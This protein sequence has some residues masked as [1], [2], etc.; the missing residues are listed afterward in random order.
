VTYTVHH[1]S[2]MNKFAGFCGGAR[3]TGYY[4]TS[5]EAWRAIEALRRA[6]IGKSFNF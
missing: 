3:I 5:D 2:A 6:R 4:D 1:V